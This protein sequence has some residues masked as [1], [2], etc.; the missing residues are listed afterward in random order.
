M[1]CYL[2]RHAQTAWNDENRLQGH[3]D[4]ALSPRGVEQA[5][6][7]GAYFGLVSNG[8][9][10]RHVY[11][12]HLRRS[13]KT[14]EAIASRIGAVPV[15]EPS[16]AEIHLGAWEGLT[17]EEVDARFEGAYQ[18]WRLV[19]SSVTIPGGEPVEAFRARVRRVLTQ[20]IS[21]HRDVDEALV[22]VS[23]GGVIAA[24][25]ADSLGADYDRLLHRV[26]ID[27]AGISAL[28]CTLDPPRVLWVNATTH[29]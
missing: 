2:V 13:Q 17:P 14:A 26:A 11:T 28:D 29:L 5:E 22:I 21:A 24:W 27:N 1:R 8:G 3:S 25:L 18:R 15:I 16:L 7:L 6:R 12:S 19:P 9:R 20:L 4:P 10:V 23:H